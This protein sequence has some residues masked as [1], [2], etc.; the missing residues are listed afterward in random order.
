MIMSDG[1]QQGLICFFESV[2]LC[3]VALCM[4]VEVDMKDPG[5]LL[6]QIFFSLLPITLNAPPNS[7][8]FSSKRKSSCQ[9]ELEGLQVSGR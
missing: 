7:F 2:G 5:D 6:A 8:P 3:P 4:L 9:E 1:G